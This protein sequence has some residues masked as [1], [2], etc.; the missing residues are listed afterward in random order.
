MA[1]NKA[2][3]PV[4]SDKSGED[5]GKGINLKLESMNDKTKNKIN[6]EFDKMKSLISYNR[7]TQ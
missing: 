2:P 5:T 7:K 6:E 4:V 1:Y 3:Q